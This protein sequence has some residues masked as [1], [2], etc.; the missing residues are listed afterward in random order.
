MSL[1]LNGAGLET[2]ISADG[3]LAT[4]GPRPRL[5]V[6]VQASAQAGYFADWQ[7]CE[8][9]YA[10]AAPG[11]LAGLLQVNFRLPSAQVAFDGETN[12]LVTVGNLAA[13]SAVAVTSQ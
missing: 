5:P 3:T 12:I 1:F 8:L 9:I 11:E 10:G 4:F 2:P 7:N 13:M 6:S